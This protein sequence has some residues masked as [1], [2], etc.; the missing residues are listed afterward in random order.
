MTETDLRTAPRRWRGPRR[1]R[2]GNRLALAILHSPLRFLLDPGICELGYTAR[3]SGQ[4]VRLPVIYAREGDTL[5]VLVGDA[6][7]KQWW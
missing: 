7:A 2:W 5:A 6:P 4:P 3:R 1:R